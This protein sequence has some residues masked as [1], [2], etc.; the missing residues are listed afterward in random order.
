MA[1]KNQHVVPHENGWAVRREGSKKVT[2]KART[3]QE[4]IEIARQIARNQ[5]VEVVTHRPDGTF[6]DRDSY[7]HDPPV[8]KD[9]RH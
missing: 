2:R 9:S 8:P 5:G 3:Q 1:K 7:G 4:A 6:R